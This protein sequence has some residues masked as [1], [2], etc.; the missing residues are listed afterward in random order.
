IGGGALP[1]VRLF[2]MKSLPAASGVMSALSEPLLAELR[3]RLQRGEQS[4]VCLNRRGYA[5]VLHCG[6]CQWKS[7]CPHCSA[8]RVFHKRD[9]T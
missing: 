7:D 1:Q 3:R 9:R 5:P 2:D 4:L 8:W 6:E